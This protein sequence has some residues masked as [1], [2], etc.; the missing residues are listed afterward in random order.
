MDNQTDF[1]AQYCTSYTVRYAALEGLIAKNLDVAKGHLSLKE[2][3]DEPKEPCV[4]IGILFLDSK[5]KPSVLADTAGNDD[6][7]VC[8]SA[9][10]YI[11]D[12]SGRVELKFVQHQEN[13]PALVSGMVLGFVGDMKD[14]QHFECSDVIFPC[15]VKASGPI[16]T[17]NPCKVLLI[18]NAVISRNGVHR[19]KMVTD[20]C[21]S[22][23]DSIVLIGDSFEEPN[24]LPP[25]EQLSAWC[26]DAS[27]DIHIIPGFSDPTTKILPQHPFHEML[28]RKG[29]IKS[30]RHCS[31][32][33]IPETNPCS[34]KIG[35]YSCTI[36]S[37]HILLDIAKY[38]PQSPED[39][40][41]TNGS[42]RHINHRLAIKL[43][44]QMVRTRHIAPSAPDTLCCV[45][46]IS[47]DPF[48]L[49]EC[50]YL[51][52]GGSAEHFNLHCGE[53]RIIGVPD[54]NTTQVALLVDFNTGETEEIEC[55]ID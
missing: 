41:V 55:A 22:H 26:S 39:I 53:T 24:T 38:V 54:F 25:I 9:T 37:H 14:G 11:E 49:K 8:D 29:S 47:E 48:F 32:N 40:Y 12:R 20:Y 6:T 30:D 44:E 1:E 17:A 7:Y 52:V 10:Y 31:G 3:K 35:P 18:S 4:V 50:D 27:V 34:I 42:S 2:L 19:L 33:I 45:P 51:I 13:L 28:F 21:K 23:L 46:F 43:L 36:L 5:E 16:P 15:P